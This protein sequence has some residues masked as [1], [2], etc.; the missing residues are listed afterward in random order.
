MK[1]VPKMNKIVKNIEEKLL[2]KLP[3][4]YIQYMEKE[5]DYGII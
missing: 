1:E 5:F 2:I 3:Q 4:E